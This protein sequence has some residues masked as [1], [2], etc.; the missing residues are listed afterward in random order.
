M[1]NK[2]IAQLF[3]QNI[4]HCIISHLIL[5]ANAKGSL[6]HYVSS[7]KDIKSN[8]DSFGHLHHIVYSGNDVESIPSN[9][10]DPF[11]SSAI[12]FYISCITLSNLLYDLKLPSKYLVNYVD[13]RESPSDFIK[14]FFENWMYSIFQMPERTPEKI[15]LNF[16]DNPSNG[17]A[18]LNFLDYLGGYP[19][20][21]IENLAKKSYLELNS[22]GKFDSSN[23]LLFPKPI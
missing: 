15:F 9:Y 1:T 5:N 6:T 4:Y 14:V 23:S 11:V 18:P 19:T 12:K 21:K 16:F 13:S 7:Q 17:N 3:L 2:P 8:Y 22:E 20:D 10:K